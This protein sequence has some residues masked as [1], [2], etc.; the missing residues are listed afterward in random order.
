MVIVSEHSA[1]GLYEWAHTENWILIYTLGPPVYRVV[2][3]R[4]LT[5]HT[6]LYY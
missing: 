2:R 6:H 5:L 3:A 4:E 1:V